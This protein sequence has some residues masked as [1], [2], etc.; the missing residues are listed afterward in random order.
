MNA[1]MLFVFALFVS[2]IIIFLSDRF[3][4]DMVALGV[5]VALGVSGIL[6]PQEAV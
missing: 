6:T 4:M 3:R 5:V 1:E 2:T